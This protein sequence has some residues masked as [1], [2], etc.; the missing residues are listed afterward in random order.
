M[1]SLLE[2]HSVQVIV[3]DS[4]AALVPKAEL[5][6]DMGEFQL[7]LQA[8]LMSQALRKLTGRAKA[9]TVK[10]WSTGPT[11]ALSSLT[12]SDRR[13]V[14]SLAVTRLQVGRLSQASWRQCPEVLFLCSPRCASRWCHHGRQ[15][16]CRQPNSSESCEGNSNPCPDHRINW[17]HPSG[18][19][20][21]TWN[22]T[23]ASQSWAS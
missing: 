20:S 22:S 12:R 3:V 6:A 15:R 4:V 17:R 9:L 21:S 1:A 14:F 23:A 16:A 19:L 18:K 8:R 2:K 5:E 10:E 11:A 13:L 7:G